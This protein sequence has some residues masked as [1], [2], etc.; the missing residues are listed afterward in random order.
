M[1]YEVIS[2]REL[3]KSLVEAWDRVLE[4]GAFFGSPFLSPWFTKTVAEV[5]NDVFVTLMLDGGRPIG[6]FPYQAPD[7]RRA[8]PVGSPMN[9]CQAVVV[10][11]RVGWSPKDLI[12]K[13]GL[14]LWDF[15]HLLADQGRL[16]PSV[17]VST[18]SPVIDLGD[19]LE[20]YYRNRKTAGSRRI[21]TLQRKRRKLIREH[22][23][24]E[25]VVFDATSG[26]EADLD[27]VIEWKIEH[28]R[29]LGTFP[30]F[31]VP[32]TVDLVRRLLHLSRPGCGGALSVLRV[33]GE[34][35]GA[36][37]GM[38]SQDVWHWWLPVYSE[39]WSA[40][41]PGGLLLMYLCEHVA[42]PEQ[43]QHIIDLGKGDDPYKKSFANDA[44]PLLE[45]HF[46]FGP[47]GSA[48]AA[49]RTARRGLA[50]L[51][52][53]SRALAPIPQFCQNLWRRTGRSR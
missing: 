4:E 43:S 2:G 11:R 7:G 51:A 29:K 36:H 45:G 24:G 22:S 35:A 17:R 26:A 50:G 39:T 40:Y 46:A 42:A 41:S 52:R 12:R 18:E 48:Y 33:E 53:R 5:R 6:F 13:S 49:L 15:D 9:D 16:N 1:D 10:D 28:C 34:I 3:D 31:T 37:F 44:Y 20:R 8:M 19:G 38:R 47:A 25:G 14:R 32:W 30:F 21:D 27:R 23:T